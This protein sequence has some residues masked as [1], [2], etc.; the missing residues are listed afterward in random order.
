PIMTRFNWIAVCLAGAVLWGAGPGRA[1]AG[2]Y[3]FYHENVMGTSLELRVQA[4]DEPAARRAEGLVLRRIDPFRR[5][6]SG[7][8]RRSEFSR[9]QSRDVADSRISP[10]LFHVLQA[11][12]VWQSRTG[13]AFDSRVGALSRLWAA[14]VRRGRL[15]DAEDITSAKTLMAPRAWRLD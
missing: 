11:S 3:E 5:V 7:F 10:E 12:E 4:V 13:G 15:P 1:R 2:D 6:F 8:D 14:C 9:W